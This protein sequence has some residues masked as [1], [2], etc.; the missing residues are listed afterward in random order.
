M[1]SQ[2]WTRRTALAVLT[3]GAA[4]A[5]ASGCKSERPTGKVPPAEAAPAPSVFT[6][7][8]NP[9]Y[10]AEGFDRIAREVFAPIYPHLARQMKDDYGIASGVA[11]DAGSGPGYW[12]IELG[13]ITE[14]KVFALDI[15]PKAVEVA[16]RNIREAGLEGR[17]EAVVGDVQRLPFDDASVD[18]V[19]SRGS[20]LFWPDKAKAFR[21]I[22][23][24]L[25][26]GGV[27]FIGGG[28]GNLLPTE[29]RDRIQTVMADRQIGPPQELEVTFEE[30]GGILR[31]AGV[32]DFRISH[33]E[34]CLCGMW[35]EF[36]KPKG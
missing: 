3:L 36:R 14:L 16:G 29:D 4:L 6:S 9:K 15:D 35:V 7:D 32:T 21:E 34:G 19:V 5:F 27:A 12:A 2:R 30:M 11:V 28:L 24:V 23:R 18:L 26:P 20:Y 10:D 25:K 33:D 17:V 8:T 22:R 1:N 31:A 13:K